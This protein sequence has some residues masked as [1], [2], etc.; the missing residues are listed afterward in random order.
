MNF[1]DGEQSETASGI[2][3]ITENFMLNKMGRL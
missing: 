1:D 2:R 3:S